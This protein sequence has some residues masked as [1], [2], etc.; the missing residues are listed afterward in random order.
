MESGSRGQLGS[1]LVQHVG[2]PVRFRLALVPP[3]SLF[4][5]PNINTVIFPF[6]SP[7]VADGTEITILWLFSLLFVF[8]SFPDTLLLR[9]I[10]H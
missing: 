7:K 3:S 6:P 1:R 5:F 10:A 4:H 2:S 9:Y 8:F